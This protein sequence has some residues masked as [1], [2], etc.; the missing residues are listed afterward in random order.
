[1]GG[2]LGGA[3]LF[4][5]SLDICPTCKSADPEQETESRTSKVENTRK[6]RFREQC[7]S[8]ILSKED[9]STGV[10]YEYQAGNMPLF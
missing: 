9:E 10:T 4:G 1:M 5:T 3:F 6:K 2:M 7:D 8:N